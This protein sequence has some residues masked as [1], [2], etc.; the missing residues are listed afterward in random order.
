MKKLSKIPSGLYIFLCFAFFYLPILVTVIFSFNESKSLTHF[1]GFSMR[2]YS[3]LIN[4]SEIMSAVYVSLT[5][6]IISTVISTI[7]GTMT[8]IGLSKCRKVLRDWTLNINNIPMMIPDIVMAVGLM[9]LFSALSIQKGYMTMLLAHICFCTPYV[10]TSVYPKVRALDVNI[11]NAALDLGAT[12]WQALWKVIIPMIKPGIYA[13]VLLAFT[14]SIDDFVIS[15]FVSGNGVKNISIV[16]YNM[17]KRTNPTMNALST[18]LIVA[19]ITITLIVNLAPKIKKTRLSR[20]LS[21]I[22]AFLGIVLLISVLIFSC[23]STN[24]KTL[25]I[26]NA[27]EY[28]DEDLIHE[29]EEKYGCRVIYET[30][31]SN[32]SMYTKINSG[33]VY[34]II[35]PSDYM[36]ER[37]IKEERIREIDYSKIPN[38]KGLIPSVLNKE[39]DPGNKYS[40]PYFWGSVG[41]LYDKTKVD[42]ADLKEGWN[43][44]RNTKYKGDIYMYDSERDSFMIAMKALGYSLNTDKKSEIDEAYQWL[45]EQSQTMAPVYAGDDVI[46]NMIS[47]NKA[48][49]VVYSGDAA[50]IITENPNLA[51]LEPQQGTNIWYDGMVITQDCT[52]TDLAH[53]FINFILDK[54]NAL[55]N[56]TAVGYSS[57]IQ[58]AYDEMT[59]TDYK[60]INAYTPRTGY[61]KD[62]VFRYQAQSIK[63]YYSSQWTKIKASGGQ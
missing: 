22:A 36:I 54:D 3:E 10:I 25:K 39:Y 12:P 11:A 33:E 46:D 24:S 48:M 56:T 50:Y 40:V 61:E 23:N 6:A 41:I 7:L 30:F 53:S 26:Y 63:E 28:I 1:T 49:A 2:W 13:G 5:V 29:F 32:E 8:A 4:S 51:Y 15:Y 19:I 37:L 35:I 60:G 9:I 21:K 43:I 45:L 31:D 58:S 16:V 44:L 57:S 18:I 52:N 62:E 20:H 27:G 59:K 55:R 17:T 14:M 34:D 47:G 42:E 38:A